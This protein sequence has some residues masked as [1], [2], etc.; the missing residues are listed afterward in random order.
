MSKLSKS[1]IEHLAKLARLQLSEKEKTQKLSV[2][3]IDER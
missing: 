3:I 2:K 1:E